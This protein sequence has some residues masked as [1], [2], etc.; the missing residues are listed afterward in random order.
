MASASPSE[1]IKAITKISP[2]K[3]S[4]SQTSKTTS[5]HSFPCLSPDSFSE[6]IVQETTDT[7]F[8][9][10]PAPK[11]KEYVCTTYTS[12]PVDTHPPTAIFCK[13]A[14]AQAAKNPFM[15][16]QADTYNQKTHRASQ[17]TTTT[18]SHTVQSPLT[19][20]KKPK[21]FTQ[22]L[23]QPVPTTPGSNKRKPAPTSERKKVAKRRK[24]GTTGKGLA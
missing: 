24:K 2:L 22:A 16:P 15:Q 1:K 4:S 17:P 11:I 8:Q 3:R 9:S 23:L 7:K 6:V 13:W 21:T 10:T 18:S 12:P 5:K 20:G 14:T 19:P